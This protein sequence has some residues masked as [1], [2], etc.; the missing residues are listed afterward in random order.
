MPTSDNPVAPE[1]V[2]FGHRKQAVPRPITF[3]QVPAGQG[4]QAE[5]DCAPL[6]TENVPAAQN[7]CDNRLRLRT[8]KLKWILQTVA[9]YR[10]SLAR[11]TVRSG[12]TPDGIGVAG[13]VGAC[14]NPGYRNHH[15]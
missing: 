11:G 13:A 8:K 6:A 4:T 2:P 14:V 15:M 5:D 7:N 10:C 9:R 1:Y 12:V 3:D